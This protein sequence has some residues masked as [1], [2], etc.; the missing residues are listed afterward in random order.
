MT[1]QKKPKLMT[2]EILSKSVSN[3]NAKAL[4]FYKTYKEI[5]DITEKIDIAMGR[6]KIYRYSSGS[7][8]NFEIDTHEIPPT[9]QSYKV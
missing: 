7:T 1:T 2:E 4:E 9:I 6:K 3:E 8:Q 5:S